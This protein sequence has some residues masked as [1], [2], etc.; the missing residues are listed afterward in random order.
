MIASMVC[1]RCKT[2]N[3]TDQ[4]YCQKCGYGLLKTN[5]LPAEERTPDPEEGSDAEE[6]VGTTI[7][8]K[9]RVLGLLGE[10]GFGSVYKVEQ[11]LLGRHKVF[12]LKIL[13]A[14]LSSNENFRTRFIREASIAMELV[15]PH[16]IPVRDFGITETG[17]LYFSMDYCKGESLKEAIARDGYLSLNRAITVT[18]QILQVL[19]ASH[20]MQII[21]RDLKPENIF[22]DRQTGSG[23]GFEIVKVGDFGLA[24][25]VKRGADRSDLTKGGIVGTPR[26]MSPE[27]SKGE[28]VDARADLY[29]VAVVFYEMIAGELPPRLDKSGNGTLTA[30]MR[31][32]EHLPPNVVVPNAVLESIARALEPKPADRY[33]SATEFRESI[34][35]LPTYTPT[36][37]D[38]QAPPPRRKF[39]SA[40]LWI[41]IVGLA[42]AC[43]LFLTPKGQGWLGDWASTLSG[44]A[45]NGKQD[46]ENRQLSGG[47]GDRSGAGETDKKSTETQKAPVKPNPEDSAPKR[48]E[49]DPPKGPPP[50]PALG[51]LED[52]VPYS[53][54]LDLVF[55]TWTFD[56]DGFSTDPTNLRIRLGELDPS[57]GFK[58]DFAPEPQ[59]RV[60]KDEFSIL[61]GDRWIQLIKWDAESQRPLESWSSGGFEFT[62]NP[63]L[64]SFQLKTKVI[65]DCLQIEAVLVR[66]GMPAH[67]RVYYY[68]KNQGLVRYETFHE[69]KKIY[70]RQRVLE[71]L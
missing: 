19:E 26:Y 57:E 69:K 47:D 22:L 68:R 46:N 48:S 12:A 10:G 36:Y 43:L 24:R 45:S 61:H 17:R 44:L 9:Y 62:S 70:V 32:R 53:Q 71:G 52:W 11:L 60:D 56:A 35:R 30:Q 27:Q 33:Q 67:T 54:G 8:G 58:T 66:D 15:H 21:H 64:A 39:R 59:W 42:L 4:Q 6:L 49:T 51:P 23:S 38:P 29:S 55:E 50:P 25:S 20:A 63:K 1:P 41:P 14:Q 16:A 37:V 7:G 13:H 3:V 40:K 2:E 28:P 31:L 18:T 34:E 65:E 5:S